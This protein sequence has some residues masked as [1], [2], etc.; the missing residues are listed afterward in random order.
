MEGR[1]EL[2]LPMGNNCTKNKAVHTPLQLRT[3]GQERNS[4]KHSH[5]ETVTDGPA[6]RQTNGPTKQVLESRVRDLKGPFRF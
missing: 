3:G 4:K 5:F 6:D 2:K 1:V